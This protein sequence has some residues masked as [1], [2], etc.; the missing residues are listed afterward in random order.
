[1]PISLSL[2]LFNYST[3]LKRGWKNQL[4]SHIEGEKRKGRWGR[5]RSRRKKN[6][7]TE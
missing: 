6:R 4:L 3:N 5:R 1:M 2:C 7:K